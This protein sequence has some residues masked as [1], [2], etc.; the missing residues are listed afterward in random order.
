MALEGSLKE[1]GLADILQLIYYQ[2]KTGVLALESRIDRVRLLF[3]EGKIVFAE[4]RRRAEDNRMGKILLRK[5]IITE[6]QLAEVLHEQ[7]LKAVKLGHALLKKGYVEKEQLQEILTS[8]ITEIITQLF[9]WKEG[10]YE[11]T[12]QGVPV[13]KEIPLSLDTQHLLMDGLRIVDEWSLLEG[14][15]T[16]ESIFLKTNK[17]DAGLS[18]EEREL[19]G[20]VDGKSDV[21]TIV[22][23]SGR[24][25]FEVSKTLIALLEKELIAP[26]Q[27]ATAVK[28]KSQAKPKEARL[29]GVGI[30][31]A[32]SLLLALAIAVI[33]TP[34]PNIVL[35]SPAASEKIDNLRFLIDAY[36]YEN[37]SYP[38][39]LSLI[40]RENDP[41]GLPYSYSAEDSGFVLFSSGPDR[42]AGTPDD[43]Y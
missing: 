10:R 24:D 22:D 27:P 1:F 35:K 8:Q 30:I 32:A 20:F 21:S 26:V 38:S 4:S 28:E 5:G 42:Q 33:S 36:M 13:D 6:E 9:A 17:T 16:L 2:R 3:H 43:V 41:W 14:K 29:P 18:A 40:T 23:L 37:G 12:P 15:I 7:K 25:N 31:I 19:L 11:F 39:S 34:K